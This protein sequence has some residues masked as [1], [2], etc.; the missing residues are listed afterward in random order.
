M[1]AAFAAMIMAFCKIMEAGAP[2]AKRGW[3]EVPMVG[4]L[5]YGAIPITVGVGAPA[6]WAIGIGC[7][8]GYLG[9][10]QL[11]ERMEAFIR[12]PRNKKG[13]E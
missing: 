2:R 9:M 5:A 1:S 11:K 7:A 13:D 12:L 8:I 3:F 6:S 4:L 10:V